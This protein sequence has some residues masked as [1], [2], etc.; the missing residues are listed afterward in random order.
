LQAEVIHHIAH[1]TLIVVAEVLEVTA[2]TATE[3][4]AV[5]EVLAAQWVFEDT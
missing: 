3:P 4:M 5:T 2:V 1:H